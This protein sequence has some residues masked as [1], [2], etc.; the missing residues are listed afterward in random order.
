MVSE[1]E[2]LEEL[3]ELQSLLELPQKVR[4]AEV[5]GLIPRFFTTSDR[6]CRTCTCT[7]TSGFARSMSSM[8]FFA[9]ASLAGVSRM[10]TAFMELICCTFLRSS[11][12]LS[13]FTTSVKSCDWTALDR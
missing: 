7:R 6:A 9:I 5:P 10:T 12:C 4:D 11:S 8:N 2:L 1:L 3:L 13:P